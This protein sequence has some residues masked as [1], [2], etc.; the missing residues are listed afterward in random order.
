[1]I[2]YELTF[3][4]GK[5]EQ[6]TAESDRELQALIAEGFNKE[7]SLLTNDKVVSWRRLGLAKPIAKQH[8]RVPA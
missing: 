5:T 8:A 6:W 7:L 3:E 1:M 2:F 4:S